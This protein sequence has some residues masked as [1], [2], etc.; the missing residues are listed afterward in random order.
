MTNPQLGGLSRDLLARTL[1]TLS[2]ATALVALAIAVDLPRT[3][4]R[5]TLIIHSETAFLTQIDAIHREALAVAAVA[6]ERADQPA[7]R[8]YASALPGRYEIVARHLSHQNAPSHTTEPPTPQLRV[9][10]GLRPT[11]INIVFHQDMLALH[12]HVLTLTSAT[13]SIAL[14]AATRELAAQLTALH[15]QDADTL[16]ALSDA[17]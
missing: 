5:N 8:A 7:L 6:A 16:R 11:E 12:Q 15:R 9:L 14:S 2:I 1:A 4:S 13:E 3:S 10:E 17:D